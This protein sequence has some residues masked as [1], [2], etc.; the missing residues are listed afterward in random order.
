MLDGKKTIIAAIFILVDAILRVFG[1]E[2]HPE[3]LMMSINNLVELFAGVM[4]VVFRVYAT[5]NILNPTV[6]LQ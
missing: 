5:K 3:Q 1:L 2:F 6:S 4:V